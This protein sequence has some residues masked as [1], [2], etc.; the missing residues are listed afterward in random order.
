MHCNTLNGAGA[1]VDGEVG[2]LYLVTPTVEFSR[3][4]SSL[5][6]IDDMIACHV[7][8]KCFGNDISRSGRAL[9]ES[10]GGVREELD[11]AEALSHGSHAMAL[12]HEPPTG[13]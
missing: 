1:S 8:P 5:D 9:P 6:L 10:D 13:L 12:P 2:S 11:V 7:E 3:S 4:G